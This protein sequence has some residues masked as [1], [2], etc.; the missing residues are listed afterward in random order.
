MHLLCKGEL[1]SRSFS[2]HQECQGR[3][4][5][6]VLQVLMASSPCLVSATAG[7]TRRWCWSAGTICRGSPTGECRAAT[8]LGL[9]L[10]QHGRAAAPPSFS[11]RQ[12]TGGRC[13]FSARKSGVTPDPSLM[14][15]WC[16]TLGLTDFRRPPHVLL[17][18]WPAQLENAA[19]RAR[20][21]ETKERVGRDASLGSG[22]KGLE[23]LLIASVG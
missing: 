7:S 15:S 14:P 10:C 9:R 22:E 23:F 1:E 5:L 3:R 8:A 2:S 12:N 18:F 19:A 21:D 20:R 16:L 6:L 4:Q 17:H 11:G 13:G